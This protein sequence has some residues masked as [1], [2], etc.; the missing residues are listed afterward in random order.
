MIKL[1]IQKLSK[2]LG[3]PQKKVERWI[4]QGKIPVRLDGNVCNFNKSTLKKWA[5]T[6]HLTFVLPDDVR[7]KEIIVKLDTLLSAMKKGG[8]HY[9]IQGHDVEEVLRHAVKCIPGLSGESTEI[10][11]QRLIERETLNSTGIGKGV[12]IP[13]PRIPVSDSGD[14]PVLCTCFLKTPIDFQSVDDKPV[15]VLFILL[16]PSTSAHL[17]LLSRLAFCVRDNNFVT[18]LKTIPKESSLFTEISRVE[19]QLDRS[20]G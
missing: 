3:L 1:P 6:H 5:T 9:D 15:F 17:H 19:E 10:L 20:E 7:K 4:S 18:F 8:V 2:G 14:R 16:S 13:H 11:L 12:A